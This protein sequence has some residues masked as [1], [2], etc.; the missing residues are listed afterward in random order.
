MP[1]LGDVAELVHEDHQ[2]EAERERPAVEPQGVRRDGDEKAE[3]LDED[4]APLE[5]R[6]PDE[7]DEPAGALERAAHGALRVDRL[8]VAEFV[9]QD[10]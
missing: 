7:D 8:F 1:R 5:R 9:H 10:P 6:A 3:E 4:E 2:H